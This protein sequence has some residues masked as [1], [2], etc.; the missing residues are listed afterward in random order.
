MK[1]VILAGGFGTR[2]SEETSVR[3]KPL[4]EIGS[5]PILWH[6]MKTYS[7]HGI[8]DFIVCCGYKGNLIKEFFADYFRSHSDVTFDLRANQIE[9]HETRVEPWRVTCVDTGT[10]TMTGGRLRRVRPYLDEKEPFFLTYGDGVADLDIRKS[11]EFHQSHGRLATLTAVQP[12]G[13]FGVFSLTGNNTAVHSFTEKPEGDG[14][15]VNGGYFVLNPQVLEYIKGDHTVWEREP[16]EQ[17]A[18]EDNLRAFKHHGFWQPMDTL[19]DKMLLDNLWKQGRAPWCKW[20]RD[21]V[22]QG[23]SAIPALGTRSHRSTAGHKRKAV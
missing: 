22:R 4:I 10:D 21:Q 20:E 19:R 5:Q 8:N 2:I 6:I 9:V 12:T 23:V 3:P 13:R 15:W 7:M 1:A 11:L 14:A 18:S 16:L 17:L